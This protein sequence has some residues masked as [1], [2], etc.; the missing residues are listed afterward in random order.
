VEGRVPD[1]MA[2]RDAYD[3]AKRGQRP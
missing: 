2:A 3:T 1:V